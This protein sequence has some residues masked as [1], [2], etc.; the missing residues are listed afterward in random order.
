[1]RVDDGAGVS[2]SYSADLH[3]PHRSALGVA[4]E[5]G[6][7]S[8]RRDEMEE[9]ETAGQDFKAQAGDAPDR[10]FESGEAS[11]SSPAPLAPEREEA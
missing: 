4:S 3:I 10:A 1:V 8:E 7:V 11:Q 6:C 9:Q 2:G 5:G